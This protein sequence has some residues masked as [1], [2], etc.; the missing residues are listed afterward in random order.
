[1]RPF[2][3]ILCFLCVDFS[4]YTQ[5]SEYKINNV[6]TADGLPT[7]NI[8]HTFK[9]SYGFLWMASYEGL[10]RWDGYHYKRYFYSQQDST[11][12][13]G[14]IVYT[15]MEDQKKRLW[16][17][18]I[19]GLNLYNRQ[20]DNF[21]RCDIGKETTKIPV[22]DIREDSQDQLWLGTS[23]GLCK[24]NYD[25]GAAKWYV[26][27]PLNPNS[28]SHDVIFRLSLDRYDNLWIGTFEGGVNK[29]SPAD[30]TFTRFLHQRNDATTICS[31][32]IKSIL[33]DHLDQVWVGS[34]DKG[35]TLLSLDG[36][37]IRQYPQLQG[38]RKNGQIQSDVSCIF[39]DQN[40]TIWVG[41]KGQALWYKEKT[42]D[43]F[44]AFLN[45]P[46]NNPELGC[47]SIA[48]ISEDNFGNLW[49]ASQ[50]HGLFL[51]NLHKN[52]FRHFYKVKERDNGLTHNVVSALH[53]DKK[54]TIWIGTDGGGLTEYE[55]KKNKFTTY[56]TQD[57]LS[58]N[59]IQE[60][61]EDNNGNLWLASWSGGVMRFN[62][63]T[64]SVQ[65]FVNIPG[66]S[67]SLILN[68]VKSILPQDSLIWI[69]THG[70]GLSVYDTKNKRFI[71]QANNTV[72][73]FNLK[74]PAWINHLFLD[75]KKRLW[76]STYGGLFLY[77]HNKRVH[78]T[79]TDNPNSISSD[80]VNMVAEDGE[81]RI[82][83]VSESGGLD[84]YNE[85]TQDFARYTE[86]FNLPGT[87]K[88]I[89][90]DLHDKIWLACNEGLISFDSNTGKTERYD[91]SDG[92]QGNSFF[93]KAILTAQDGTLYFGSARGMNVFHPDTLEASR[94]QFE[95]PVYLTNLYIYD[96]LQ[97]LGNAGSP[98]K[99]VLS[100][101]DTLI[102]RPN[103][104]FFSIGYAALNLYSPSKTQYAYKLEG[105]HDNWIN[106]G[107]ET[108]ASFTDLDPGHFI[109]RIKYT[110]LSGEWHEADKTLHITILPPWYKTWWFNIIAVVTMVSMVVAFFYLR[111]SGIRKRNRILEAEVAKRTHEL[112]E[113]NYY[114]IEKN[115][116]IKLQNEKLEEFNREILRQSEKILHH[117][118][119]NLSQ[120]QEL[121]KT[122]QELHK[123]NQTKD[124]FFSIL[125]HDLRNPVSALSGVAE[126]LKLNLE[127]LSK[128]DIGQYVES[129]YRSS[130]S[131]YNLLINLLSWSRTQSRNIQYSPADFDISAVIGKNIVLFEPQS[132]NK[133]IRLNFSSTARHKVW[134]DYN[135]VD[136]I[137]RNLVDN[138]IK[139]SPQKG[140]VSILCE[141]SEKE[142]RVLIQDNGTGM[143]PEQLKNLFKIEKKFVCAGTAGETGTGLGLVIAQEF[144]EANKGTITVSSEAGKGSLFSFTLPKSIAP[145]N[146]VSPPQD[147]HPQN[148][149]IDFPED[150][151]LKIKGKR[152][153]II[154]DDKEL[155][156]YL[157]L[158]L[159]DTFE[160]F[161]AQDGN[162]GLKIA[163]ETQPAVIISDIMMPVMDGKEFCREVKSI[164]A[165]SHI[166]VILL[167]SQTYEEGQSLGYGAGADVYLS[168]PAKK[169]IL[170][171]VI[172]NF[173]RV[174]ERIHQR[175]LDSENHYP[176]DV[177]LNQVDEEFLIHVISIIED[178]LSDPTFDYKLI[179]EQ[180]A[181]SRTV[182]YAKVKALTGQGVHEF[183]KCIRLKKSLKLLREK[184]L[185]ISQIAYEVGFSSHSYFNKCFIKQYHA[186]PKD[187]GKKL[188]KVSVEG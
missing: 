82:W 46:Y 84:R 152:V 161:E 174:Q 61:K 48:G 108:K 136:T 71:N 52:I 130:Q 23:Y 3:L 7:D 118:K 153:L 149:V 127:Q 47:V 40:K 45:S 125:A 139:F 163:L 17:G 56:T 32:K 2:I 94:K 167:T 31:N 85:K 176:D 137:I 169:E 57:G 62:P 53:E 150:K 92:L 159:S 8:I 100:F 65:T 98:L 59:A 114:L 101:T 50:T 111:L 81:G 158:N 72:F 78:F 36:E 16:I 144:I 39:E 35:V 63:R 37:V 122:V 177:A 69:G 155:R 12:L 14:N 165:T 110:D 83:V 66:N 172:Y 126:S 179:C 106:T 135:M 141:E 183:I 148:I 90:F 24:Y 186:S 170:F 120:N 55:P 6:S 173:I 30:K 28:L 43:E 68:N 26:H 10:I 54:G 168:K 89:T 49:F 13:S 93:H 103:Q 58:S 5:I 112:S 75:S 18:T 1:M 143:N 11:S 124:R 104:S 74:E 70:E 134:A 64:K 99:K 44:L 88:A 116:E 121:E 15:I 76:V 154:D 162:E 21:I 131:V 184:K 146:T 86:K 102:L 4:A 77:E 160:I 60:I 29:F 115:E 129:I 147:D 67:N 188:R 73:P 22:N 80:F 113:A 91:Q 19:D 156:H 185:N 133:N 41:I 105:L 38:D 123:S 97:S 175:I 171:Q 178:N 187:Y 87:I 142:I 33:V 42:S 107:F 20:E 117:Q 164:P 151:L 9:D 95:V 157:R 25:G 34:Y 132:L 166:P 180:T 27:D 119:Q 128:K 181:L 145:L 140:V 79:P 138:S 109:F 182:L 96:Q 51:T